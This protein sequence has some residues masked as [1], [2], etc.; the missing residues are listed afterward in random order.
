MIIACGQCGAKN[1]VPHSKL[2]AGPVC[3]QCKGK[4]KVRQPIAIRSER[5]FDELIEQASLP[6]LVDF[7][8]DWCGPCRMVAP[9]LDALAKDRAG[10]L[11][12]AK[13]DTEALPSVAARYVVRSIPTLILF[14]DGN[15]VRRQAGAMTAPQIAQAFG[16]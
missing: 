6:V 1:R 9:Q 12:I 4:L 16:I 13:V 2:D 3:G 5:E 10:H 15:L 7:W 8:A 14:R 11:V